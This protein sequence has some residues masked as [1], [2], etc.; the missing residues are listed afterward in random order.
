MKSI[1]YCKDPVGCG[2]WIGGVANTW[3][4]VGDV[5]AV[6]SS[7]MANIHENNKMASVVNNGQVRNR[8]PCHRRY[9]TPAGGKRARYQ[10]TK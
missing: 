1:E 5:Q 6:W 2:Q 4:T 7:V 8:S 9:P 3:R 10:K